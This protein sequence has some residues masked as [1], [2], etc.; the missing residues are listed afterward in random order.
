MTVAIRL[1][2]ADFVIVVKPA[3]IATQPLRAGTNLVFAPTFANEVAERFPE[4]Q[5]VGGADWGAVY[6]VDRETSGLVVFARNQGTYEALREAFSKSGVEKEYAAVVEGEITEPGR[7]EWPIGPD[8]KSSKRVRV[9]RNVAEARRMK[10]QEAVTTY[11]P[12]PVSGEGQGV[13]VLIKTGRRPQIRAHMA[14]I[15]HPIVGDGLYGGPPAD[16]LHLHASRLRFR[17]PRTSQ[18]V[19]AF[20]PA[21]FFEAPPKAP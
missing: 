9:Y 14:A 16:R 15:G 5:T 1:E 10:A 21:P 12:L 3:G 8:P 2:D 6:R 19:E 13:R 4:I 20:S 18:W 11:S 17:H 7:I